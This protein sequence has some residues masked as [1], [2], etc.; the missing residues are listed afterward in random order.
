MTLSPTY[1]GTAYLLALLFSLFSVGLPIVVASCPMPKLEGY[2]QCFTCDDGTTPGS[3]K[4]TNTV[5]RSC[6]V[7]RYAADRNTTEFLQAHYSSEIVKGAVTTPILI[8]DCRRTE[9]GSTFVP[10][11]DTSPPFTQDI[12]ILISSLLI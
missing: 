6:C 2:S 4:L 8:N 1:R 5:D 10:A 12:P 3:A 11:T 7:T 9:T